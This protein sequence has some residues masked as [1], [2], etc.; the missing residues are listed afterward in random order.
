MDKNIYEGVLKPTR[1][2]GNIPTMMVTERNLG[3]RNM[4]CQPT[5]RRA[6]MEKKRKNWTAKMV[7]QPVPKCVL[8]TALD[9]TLM[10]VKLFRVKE[11]NMRTRGPAI[12]KKYTQEGQ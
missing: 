7:I 11:R 8:Y 6:V 1:K 9:T 10:I 2:N 12:E 4:T 5:P 3:N